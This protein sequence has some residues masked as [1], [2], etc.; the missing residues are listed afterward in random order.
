MEEYE[1]KALNAVNDW[2]IHCLRHE[3]WC[4]ARALG[5]VL[6]ALVDISCKTTVAFTGRN[7]IETAV[8]E[9]ERPSRY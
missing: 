5:K 9:A 3:D 4:K 8:N 7:T 6:E 2:L 1:K